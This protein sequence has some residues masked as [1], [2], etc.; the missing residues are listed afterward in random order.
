MILISHRGNLDGP[1]TEFEN[2]PDH[3]ESLL[4]LGTNVEI[5]VWFYS[6]DWYLGHDS[7]LYKVD[8]EFL[9]HELLWCHAKNHSALHGM[10]NIGSHCFWHE[11]D[12][13]TITSHNIIWM[14]PNTPMP[15]N[16]EN[17]VYV[18]KSSRP[19]DFPKALYGLCTDYIAY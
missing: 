14:H 5:D 16:L 4:A 11:D 1:N 3:I 19:K 10:L 2:N 15:T 18:S 6:G 12:H 17:T 8:S 9:K 7:P 13:Y